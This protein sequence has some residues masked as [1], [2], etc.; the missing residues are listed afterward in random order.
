MLQHLHRKR[1]A[2]LQL[3]ATHMLVVSTE[4]DLVLLS[5]EADWVQG[6]PSL[7]EPQVIG[8]PHVPCLWQKR[9][10]GARDEDGPNSLHISPN[11][12]HCPPLPLT[13]LPL[14]EVQGCKW[15]TCNLLLT[16][17]HRVF[18]SRPLQTRL[19]IRTP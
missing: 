4:E 19:C 2:T 18:N 9:V 10:Q 13:S 8:G 14:F 1:K 7:T 6:V 12:L 16:P 17:L 3:P 11:T 5:K 15:Q